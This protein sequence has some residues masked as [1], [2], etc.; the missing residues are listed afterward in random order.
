MGDNFPNVT[1][2]INSALTPQTPD[3]RSILI[4]GSMVAGTATSGALIEDLN[5]KAS[6]NTAF[7][8][9][10]QV[11]KAGRACI[12]A[13][14]ISRIRPKVAAIGLTDNGAG[15]A[16]T[17][18]VVFA[19]NATAAGTITIYVDSKINGKYEIPVAV[20]DTP[21]EIGDAF[22]AL[23][24]ANLDSPVTASN[25]TGTVTLT[26][27]NDGTEGNTIGLKYDLGTVTGTTVALTAF[28]SGAT[29]PV[30]TTLFDAIADRRFT[31]IV[32]PE[33]W[34][35]TTLT[36][37]TE[38]RFN[39]DNKIL[40]GVGIVC[41]VDTYSNLNTA[42]DALNQKTLAVIPNKLVTG[43]KTEGGA[44]FES[45]IVIA[46]QAAAYRE[47]RIT[48]NSNVSSITTS[49]KN[50]GGYYFGAI[51]YH[52]TP[53]ANLPVIEAGDDF[54]D[55]EALE[56]ENSGGWLLRNNAANTL[57]IS[58]EAVTTYKT[59]SLGN[60]DVTF[61]YL[62]YVDTLS[63][64]REYFFNNSKAD[65]SQKNLTTGQMIAG[66]PQI[67]R[68]GFIALSMGYYA[69]LSGMNGNAQYG[70]LRA[71]SAEAKAFKQALEDTVVV[72]LSTGTITSESIANIVTQLRNVIINFTPTFE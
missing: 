18:E 64:V 13:L 47:L 61:K 44:I 50:L 55:T 39:V 36:D 8:R 59:D 17:G 27:V 49:G 33:T 42:L 29:N 14:S 35:V 66:L 10:S 1:A 16:A 23:V 63:L 72:T 25:A 26:A 68:E 56:L 30:L 52:N 20:D 31:T 6:F 22:V 65:L 69:N 60:S 9:T 41:D 43:N 24:T 2:N 28:A 58:N 38:S 12:E 19:T 40:D 5:S 4:I 67:N 62:N 21:T 51:P 15:V 53:F 32:Y 54:S 70:L 57:I 45:P 11:A 34:G 71:G 37:E 3:E 46:A 48:V 7:G